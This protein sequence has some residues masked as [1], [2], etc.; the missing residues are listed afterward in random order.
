MDVATLAAK[1][2][3]VFEGV[4]L[5]AYQ[6]AGMV[7]TIGFGHTAGVTPQQI[8]T[9]EQAEAWLAE[10]CS[11]L[12]ALV[13]DKPLIAAAAYVSFGYNVGRHPLELVLAGTA[14]LESFCHV[15]GQVVQGLVSRRALEQALIDSTISEVSQ[16]STG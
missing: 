8:C 12:I 16:T 10:D 11:N 15:H 6:D 2:I 1:L 5:V 13:H 7:W 14:K 3:R 4:R 9:I